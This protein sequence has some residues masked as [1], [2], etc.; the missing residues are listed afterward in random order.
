MADPIT[1]LAIALLGLIAGILGGL[2][3]VGGSVIML[4]G[5]VLLLGR[6]TGEE[7]HLYQAAAMIVNVAVAYPAARRHA[8][9]GVIRRDVLKWMLPLAVVFV[10]IGV[11]LSN[12]PVFRKDGALWLGRALALFLIYVVYTNA[13]KLWAGYR[14]S[15][16]TAESSVPPAA[17]RQNQERVTAFRAGSLGGLMGLIA[18]MLGIGGGALVVPMQ[19]VWMRLPLKSCIGNSS[20]VM[21]VSAGLG[22][23]YKNLSLPEGQLVS[24]SLLIAACLMPTA[25]LGSRFGAGLTHRISVTWVRAVFVVL[26][27]VA[28]FELLAV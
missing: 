22:A 1:L 12:L 28:A 4:P 23:I 20:A 3:G 19:Q 14:A 2:L 9:A 10:L 18:G 16:K 6:E 26:M 15:Q 17:S 5:L 7:Q 11:A 27:S 24:E 8:Q 25:F 21:L 13:R